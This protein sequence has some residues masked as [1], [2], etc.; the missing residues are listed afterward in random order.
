MT[1]SSHRQEAVQAFVNALKDS[2]KVDIAKELFNSIRNDPTGSFSFP[3]DERV[4]LVNR[5][6]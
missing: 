1:E 2:V 3:K 5:Y 6:E 4:K